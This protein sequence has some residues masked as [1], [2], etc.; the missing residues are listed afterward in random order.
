MSEPPKGT[1]FEET[2]IGDFSRPLAPRK[3]ASPT[4]AKLDATEASL[5]EQVEKTQE[6]LK[7][8]ERYEA[9]LK[10]IGITKEDA[11]AIV[12]ALL[13]RGCYAEDVPI[14]SRLKARFRTRLYRDTQRVQDFLEKTRPMYQENYNEVVFKYAL[15]SSLEAFG[16]TKFEHPARS[17]DGEK[18]E[19]AFQTRL[20]F[21]EDL[22]D[23]TVR[24]LYAKLGKFDQKIRTCLEEGA[25]ENF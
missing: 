17:A 9:R 21:V 3:D 15:A 6:A 2:R 22:P 24:L 23:D 11:A 4:A 25:V 5:A 7:P 10:E 13:M 19:A 12:D 14:T 20:R 8:L 1:L 18:I 16:G